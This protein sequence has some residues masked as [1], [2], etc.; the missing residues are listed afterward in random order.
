MGRPYGSARAMW[1][2]TGGAIVDDTTVTFVAGCVSA[3]GVGFAA[4]GKSRAAAHGDD[5]KD[6]GNG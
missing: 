6:M 3:A 5:S 1:L 2:G 4:D